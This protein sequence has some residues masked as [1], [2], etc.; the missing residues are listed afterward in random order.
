MQNLTVADIVSPLR[1]CPTP[2]A[3]A[4]CISTFLAD[5]ILA[6]RNA[7]ASVGIHIRD[8]TECTEATDAAR[9]AALEALHTLDDA[10]IYL[11]TWLKLLDRQ[12]ADPFMCDTASHPDWRGSAQ[13]LL[14]SRPPLDLRPPRA[15]DQGGIRAVQWRT[16]TVPVRDGDRELATIE[17]TPSLARVRRALTAKV[18]RSRTLSLRAASPLL[19]EN[20]Y[21]FNTVA[22]Q[23]PETSFV[24]V[25]ATDVGVTAVTRCAL[26]TAIRAADDDI[27]VLVLPELF[28]PQDAVDAFCEELSRYP[29]PAVTVIGLT[30]RSS[31]LNYS[32]D[33]NEAI[34]V[35]AE[36]DILVIHQKTVAYSGPSDTPDLPSAE[37]LYLGTRFTVLELG[38]L[39]LLP[40]ICVEF[41]DASASQFLERLHAN[42]FGIPSR[43]PSTGPHESEATRLWIGG[44][45]A[46]ACANVW[47]E[48]PHTSTFIRWDSTSSHPNESTLR[49]EV[50]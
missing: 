32:L 1:D 39:C 7:L 8:I 12:L 48:A 37:N 10:T 41:F 43:S 23:K 6:F 36:G 16:R 38:P 45:S 5:N 21:K 26:D 33:L 34:A 25:H 46:T 29:A 35:C 9:L 17:P 28:L 42:V 19:P 24:S 14:K 50:P 22:S 20:A 27:D 18:E 49:I 15:V 40:A 44:R 31:D 4:V 30:H 3:F 47:H 2:S 11:G 13:F